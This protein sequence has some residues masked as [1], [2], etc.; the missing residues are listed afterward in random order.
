[1][2]RARWLLLPAA[3]YL[4]LLLDWRSAPP[5]RE[6]RVSRAFHVFA[7][8]EAGA[9]AV[10]LSP[11]LPVVRGGYGIRRA[12]ALRERDPLKVRALVLRA[13]SRTVAIVLADLVLV[14]GQLSR[15]LE[16]RVS[17]LKLEGVVLAATHTHSS[18]GAFDSRWPAQVV[19]MGRYR[20]EV[21]SAILDRAEQAVREAEKRLASVNVRTAEAR[22]TGWAENRS[23]PG[24]PVDD[25]LTVAQLEGEAGQPV[26]TLAIVAAHPTLFPRAAPELSADYP[27]VAMER[28]ELDGGT[29]FLFQGAEGDARP[30]GWGESAIE[31]AGEFVSRSVGEAARAARATAPR[32]GFAQAE[33]G[34]P[35]A[36]PQAIRPFLIRRPAANALQW[37]LPRTASVTVV[38]LGDVLLLGV[39]GE[40]TA[41]AAQQMAA[42]IPPPAAAE[43]RVRVVA[44]VDDYIGYI[45]VPERI[46]DRRGEARRTWF[47]PELLD[48]VARGLAA[49]A[50]A[51]AAP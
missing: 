37:M 38:G 22:L 33:V 10:R 31:A 13:A 35:P 45:D 48:V 24:A 51:E 34:L 17:D 21:A 42:T 8:L 1:V 36:E 50:S 16:H 20:P 39:P 3:L 19:G 27:G 29:A 4:L 15:G 47:G 28:L 6:A 40:P 18:V 32:L 30:P 41:S 43:R 46:R 2:R 11:A 5:I 12:T 14:P 23:S 26:A 7:P 44:L 9:A 25:V 49:A